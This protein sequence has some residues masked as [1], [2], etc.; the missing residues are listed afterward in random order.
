MST[1]PIVP[2][3]PTELPVANPSDPHRVGYANP[4]KHS[5]FKP[6]VSGNPSGRPKQRRSFKQDLAAAL[7]TVED[8]QT[9]QQ[10][11][12][13]V[14]MK[15]A[16][17]GNISALKIAIPMALSLDAHENDFEGELTALQQK[18]VE[19]FDRRTESAAPMATPS[20]EGDDHD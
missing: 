6:G 15:A 18:L 1:N 20:H 17:N 14:L 9:C 13:W 10:S 8:G 3:N 19:D 2:Q 16:R 4:P 11:M 12:I 5:Q 7:D